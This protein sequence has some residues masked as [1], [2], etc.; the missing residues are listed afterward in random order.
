M[1]NVMFI[2]FNA[3]TDILVVYTLYYFKL[4]KKL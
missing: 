2:A 3:D 4:I 1:F